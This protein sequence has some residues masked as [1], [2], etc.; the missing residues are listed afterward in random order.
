MLYQGLSLHPNDK[1]CSGLP[2]MRWRCN[3]LCCN[4]S[5]VHKAPCPGTSGP[6]GCPAPLHNVIHLFG[7][8]CSPSASSPPPSRAQ[9][10][11]C[12]NLQAGRGK[13]FQQAWP[14]DLLVGLTQ[15]WTPLALCGQV[16]TR[17]MTGRTGPGPPPRQQ[18]SKTWAA[19]RRTLPHA[20]SLRLKASC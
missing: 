3:T 6:L 15:S 17:G 14:Q 9:M 13:V 1:D 2:P 11:C 5:K 18:S 16:A 10:R 4:V 20:T 8:M 19:Q 12:R 7:Y